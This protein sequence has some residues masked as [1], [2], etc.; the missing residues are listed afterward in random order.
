MK[1]TAARAGILLAAPLFLWA[2]ATAERR[3]APPPFEPS[4]VAF[5]DSVQSRTFDWF[6]DLSD[7]RT[8]LTPDRWPTESFSSVSAVGFA[9]THYPGGVERGWGT[10]DEAEARGLATL[11]FFWVAR[12]GGDGPG[13]TG[14]RGCFCR[15]R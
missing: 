3:E 6:W 1:A 15:S 12:Q 9:L 13:L 7:A 8:G 11:R 5:L 2:C 14:D 10:R 4:A